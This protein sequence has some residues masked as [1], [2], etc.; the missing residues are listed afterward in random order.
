MRIPVSYQLGATT[1][2]A[3]NR[4]FTFAKI[5]VRDAWST[6]HPAAE[7]RLH[8]KAAVDWLK[9]A[10]SSSPDDGVSYGY[11]LKGGWRPSYRETSGY[12]AVTFFNVA[13][14]LDDEDAKRRA[15]AICDWLRSIQNPDGAISNPQLH[16]NTGIVFDTGQVLFGLVRAYEETKDERFKKAARSAGDWLVNVADDQGI[17][18][19]N[20]HNEI[21]H[22]YNSRVA[23][24][25]LRLNQ[26]E[27]N[28]KWVRVARANL[29][30]AKQQQKG[31]LFD[32]CA[33]VPGLAPFTHTIAYAIR[34]LMESG[35]LL[36]DE[37]YRESARVAAAAMLD[38]VDDQGYVPGQVSVEG[39]AAARYCCLTG[40]CQLAIIWFKLYQRLGDEAFRSAGVRALKYVMRTQNLATENQDIAGAIKGSH[41]TWGKYSRLTYP[42]WATKFFA[43]AILLGLDY[44]S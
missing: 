15:V 21:A 36:E 19:R 18:T 44:L 29:D 33:F 17:W 6:D 32:Q 34:G 41:P 3:I 7:P 23:W 13:K 2:H 22:T 20:T 30:F 35:E 8:L 14:Q 28:E 24:S 4:L 12:I 42:N 40:N 43:D 1:I 31:S 27:P 9:R 26:I 38:H 25:L 37:E 39:N 16:G 5:T 10:H 11:S